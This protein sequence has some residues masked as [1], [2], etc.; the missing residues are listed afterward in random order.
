MHVSRADSKAL[1]ASIGAQIRRRRQKLGISQGALAQTAGVHAN[2]VGRTERGTY[3]PT[4]L[5]LHA[6]ASA[7]NSSIAALVRKAVK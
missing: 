3:N 4:V 5:V 2:V 7:L 6:L 1:L